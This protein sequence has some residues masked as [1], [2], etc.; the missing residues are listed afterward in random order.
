MH[1]VDVLALMR[2]SSVGSVAASPLTLRVEP[3]ATSVLV[4]SSSSLGARAKNWSSLGFEP[5]QP[6]SM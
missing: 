6:P 1:T 2:C 3:N 5:G 4:E